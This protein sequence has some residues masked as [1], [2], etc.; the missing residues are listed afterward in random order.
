MSALL[1]TP[2]PTKSNAVK[3]ACCCDW[4]DKCSEFKAFFDKNKRELGKVVE[5]RYADTC[6]F[7]N[8]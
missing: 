3:K 8:F 6:N 2:P 5:V 4:G 1:F 7:L